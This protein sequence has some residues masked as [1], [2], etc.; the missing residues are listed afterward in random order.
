MAYCTQDDLLKMIPP[1]EL[2]ELTADSGDLP[3]GAVVAEA[4]AKAAAEIDSYLGVR[5]PVPLPAPVPERVRAL[6]VDL[7]LY[8]LYSRRSLA[9]TV[10]RQ[11]YEA[12]VA[13]LKQV[14]AGQA[15]VEGV[16]VETPGGTREIGDLSSATRVFRRDLTEDW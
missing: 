14:A 10:R 2:T 16:G 4:I 3:D 12:A 6:A 13:F 7:A 15:L 1:G 5:Y 11:K 8:H 9:P